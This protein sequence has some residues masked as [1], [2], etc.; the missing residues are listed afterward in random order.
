[1]ECG[2]R[3]NLYRGMRRLALRRRA[4]MALG[5]RG[6]GDHPRAEHEV[7]EVAALFE[8]QGQGLAALS[9]LFE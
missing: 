7:A 8:A 9:N 2:M 5:R 6:S 1:M 3:T 4:T